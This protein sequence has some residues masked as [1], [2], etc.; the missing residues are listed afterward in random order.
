MARRLIAA[1]LAAVALLGLSGCLGVGGGRGEGISFQLVADAEE[2][3]VYR[4]VVRAYEQR[5]GERVR[6]VA[7]GERRDHLAK[8][9]TG[10][11]AGR[12]PD[13]FLINQ[14]NAGGFMAAGALDPAGPRLGRGGAPR[15]EDFYPIALDAFTREGT[16]QCL[17][18]NVSS[19]VVYVNRDLF[20][21]AGVRV[22]AKAWSYE[23][24]LDAARRLTRDGV[25][26]VGVE[27]SVIR[28]APFVWGAGGEVVD[29]TARPERFTL[30]TPEARRGLRALFELRRRGYAPSANEA[31][32]RPPD[33]RFL[34]GELAMLL[35][36]RREVPTLRTIKDFDW[37]VAPFPV[38]ERRAAVLHSDGFCVAKQGDTEK[39][40]AFAEFAGGPEGQR[41]L[42]R[43]GRTVPSLRAVAESPAFLDPGA[44]PRSSR[45]FLDAVPVMRRLPTSPG[46]T[47]AEEAAERVLEQ[48]YYGRLG[49]DEALRRIAAETDGTL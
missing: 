23:E 1:A 11:G 47:R 22:P 32:S 7:V 21:R 15:R 45:V 27:P 49:L 9:A 20:A 42:A 44:R 8:L 16:V 48:A 13:V 6:L 35:S 25:N 18:Q 12:P 17:P 34:A 14:R 10:F 40:W 37:D 38:L 5:S 19:L 46:W 43:G 28:V 24:F 33:E 30:D 4:E 39:A 26:G 36:S 31:E 2:L 29:D 41:I 3:A